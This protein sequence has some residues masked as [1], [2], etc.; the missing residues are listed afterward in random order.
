MFINT[1][2]TSPFDTIN[3]SE[4]SVVNLLIILGCAL[5]LG[6]IT[7]LFYVLMKRKSGYSPDF[8]ITIIILP[9]IVALVIYFVSDNIA[10][11]LSLAGIFALAR[12]RSEQKNTEDIAYIFLSVAIGLSC[13][14]GYV[15]ASAML[16]IIMLLVL[17]V[18]YL[19]RFGVPSLQN[20]RLKIIV[21]EDLNYDHLFDDVLEKYCESYVLNK[22]KT[23]DFGTMFE[24]TFHIVV[25]KSIEQ[26]QFIDE[27]RRRNGNLNITLVVARNDKE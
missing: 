17:M 20:M 12:F 5:G 16:T 23:S 24:L 6:L 21:P 19:T 27:L 9:T 13:G 8:P 3:K 11:G 22:V 15:L 1:I 18:L 14:L 7:S 10:G 2:L 25:K 26:K 4:F